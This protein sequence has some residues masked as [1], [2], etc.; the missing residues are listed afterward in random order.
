MD[1]DEG[2]R[3]SPELSWRT[4]AAA[5]VV[6][7]VEPPVVLE[8]QRAAYGDGVT[9]WIPVAVLATRN[10]L[11]SGGGRRTERG[12]RLRTPVTNCRRCDALFKGKK[13]QGDAVLRGEEIRV[14]RIER[15]GPEPR[16]RARPE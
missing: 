11:P 4:T 1:R 14:K 9:T 8:G 16:L 7:G 10:S 12:G 5:L 13:S 2:G 3:C 6:G 15:G